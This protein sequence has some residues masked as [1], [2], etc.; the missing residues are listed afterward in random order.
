VEPIPESARALEELGPFAADE[1]EERL[2]AQAGQVRELVPDCV[3]I[4]LASVQSGLTLTLVATSEEIAV[5][6]AVQY[7]YGGPC[8]DGAQ[9]AQVLEYNND[10]VLDER[11]WQ[12]FA[13]ATSA[14]AVASTLTLPI[15]AG[16]AVVGSVNL[17]AASRNAFAGLHDDLARIFD[18][19]APGAVTNAD[20][21]FSTRETAELAPE[22]LLEDLRVQ[23]AIG[24]I[25]ASR[26]I[27]VAEAHDE[28]RDA[29]RRAGISEAALAECLIE[30]SGRDDPS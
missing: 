18:A 24:I 13:E 15:L 11:R 3:G 7:L 26:D 28:L 2:R 21:S 5:L 25:A 1:L 22:K 12:H 8:V 4:S 30:I 6:D 23:M 16:G 17:Y 19:W 10:N 9:A 14:A 27:A 20:L 29:A